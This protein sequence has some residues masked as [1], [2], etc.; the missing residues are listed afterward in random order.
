MKEEKIIQRQADFIEAIL[1]NEAGL[2]DVFIPQGKLHKLK[3]RLKIL[4]W[5]L[6][7]DDK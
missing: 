4:N 1:S 2:D 5:V 7:K 6:D 3:W